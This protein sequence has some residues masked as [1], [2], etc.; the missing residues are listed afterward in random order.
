MQI[1]YVIHIMKLVKI[2][3]NNC[4]TKESLKCRVCLVFI[5]LCN[6]DI[7]RKKPEI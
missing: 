4:Y 1:Y 3:Y 5:F 6:I 7:L 2:Y